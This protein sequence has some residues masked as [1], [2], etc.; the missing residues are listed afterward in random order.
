MTQDTLWALTPNF[1]LLVGFLRTR[2]LS[3]PTNVRK[4]C[5]GV[6]EE[7]R[8]PLASLSPPAAIVMASGTTG[9]GGSGGQEVEH[10][11]SS[12]GT[13]SLS[14]DARCTHRPLRE[15]RRWDLASGSMEPP[16]KRNVFLGLVGF[17]PELTNSFIEG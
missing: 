2:N 3:V 6:M 9:A 15:K 16:R 12:I 13:H 10:D 17:S 1:F 7:I 4:K 8:V 14:W 11:F 5:L